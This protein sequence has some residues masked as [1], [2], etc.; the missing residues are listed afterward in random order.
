V[1]GGKRPAALEALENTARFGDGFLP[2]QDGFENCWKDA[3][4]Q[5]VRARMEA[6]LPR[7]ITRPPR[8]SSRIAASSRKA[9]RTTRLRRVRPRQRRQ[10]HITRVGWGNA[11][12]E[13]A[14]A[15]RGPRR[16]S[17]I[18]VDGPRRI[19]YAVA[20]SAL[21]AQGRKRRKNAVLA[22]DIDKAR[23]CGAW[24]CPTRCS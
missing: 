8:S 10:G 15:Q 19:L 6:R 5:Q 3:R 21:T 18:A 14:P 24:K 4:F 16:H 9:S 23:C 20:T 17:R 22:F 13:F 2:T 7:S 1:R 12:T 11:L